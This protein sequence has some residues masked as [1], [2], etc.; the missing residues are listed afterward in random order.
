MVEWYIDEDFLCEGFYI[1]IW[2]FNELVNFAIYFYCRDNACEKNCPIST[3]DEI[4]LF[5]PE[6]SEAFPSV[7]LL[8]RVKISNSIKSRIILLADDFII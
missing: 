2:V 3:A 1:R 5:K 7:I 8:N 4:F 6:Q